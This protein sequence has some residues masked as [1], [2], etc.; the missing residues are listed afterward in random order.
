MDHSDIESTYISINHNRGSLVREWVE[1]LLHPP[2]DNVQCRVGVLGAWQ[3][4]SIV[5]GKIG[6]HLIVLAIKF[7]SVQGLEDFV[8]VQTIE[9]RPRMCS[10]SQV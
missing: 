4:E 2:Y 1:S 8:Q 3:V 9:K 7:V 5:P 10:C 6:G